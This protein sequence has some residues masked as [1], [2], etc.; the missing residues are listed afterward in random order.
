MRRILTACC[1][2]LLTLTMSAPVEAHHILGV[3]H[4]AYKDNFPQ[5][6]VLEYPAQAG[7]Y[8]VLLSAYP[9]KPVPGEAASLVFYMTVRATGLPYLTPV[10]VRVLTAATFGT[11][12]EIMAPAVHEHTLNQFKYT[13]TF[14][15]DG[16]YVVELTMDVEGTPEVIPFLLVAGNPRSPVAVPLGVGAGLLFL[17]IIV[18]ALK[19]KRARREAAAVP[20]PQP[21][22]A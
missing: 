22:G 14:P 2:I 12:R 7:P 4:Y 8:D 16:E 18:R 6:P 9:G 1:G 19:L 10:S 13:V 17:A 20:A 11:G 21:Q 5:V 3:P 15:E